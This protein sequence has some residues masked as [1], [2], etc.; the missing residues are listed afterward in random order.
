MAKDQ[1]QYSLDIQVVLEKVLT[2]EMK[3][4]MEA[5]I[6]A[7]EEGI[8]YRVRFTSKGER[9]GESEIIVRKDEGDFTLEDTA[10]LGYENR[11]FAADITILKAVMY[12]DMGATTPNGG[13]RN[14]GIRE[15][16]H[17]DW[18]LSFEVVDS[19]KAPKAL[20]HYIG[21]SADLTSD[22]FK[23]FG[24]IDLAFSMARE[25]A[26]IIQVYGPSGIRR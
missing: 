4:S 9:K 7:P 19:K 16:N 25:R 8:L 12:T 24:N 6:L 1:K 15:P 11:G 26:G 22:Y 5:E 20:W 23:G 17:T 2:P 13:V 10:R 18:T 3:R 21:L 14:L